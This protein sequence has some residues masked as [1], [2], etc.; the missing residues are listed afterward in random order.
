MKETNSM[1]KNRSIRINILKFICILLPLVAILTFVLWNFYFVEVKASYSKVEEEES[2]VVNDANKFFIQTFANLQSDLLFLSDIFTMNEDVFAQSSIEW[3]S[4]EFLFFSR[5][6]FV[7]DQLRFMDN[8]GIEI[9][10]INFNKG[11]PIIVEKNK[12][13]DKSEEYYFK[14]SKKINRGGVYISR[15]DL[16]LE[17]GVVERPEGVHPENFIFN[18]V[19]RLHKDVNYVKP[20][21]RL[22]TPAFDSKGEKKGVVL[23]NYFGAQLLKD[24]EEITGSSYGKSA[25]VDSEGFWLKGLEKEKEWGFV[26]DL[27]NYENTKLQDLYPRVWDL[28]SKKEAGQFYTKEGLFT[29]NTVYPLSRKYKLSL[30]SRDNAEEEKVGSNDYIWKA[31]TFVPHSKLNEMVS[32][33]KSKSLFMCAILCIFIFIGT[34]LFLQIDKRRKLFEQKEKDLFASVANEKKR[35]AQELVLLN[36]QLVKNEQQLKDANVA[37]LAREQQLKASNNELQESKL[38]LADTIEKL[39]K[40]NSSMR[41]RELRIIEIKKKIKFL[42]EKLKE[43]GR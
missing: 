17:K 42:E 3:F 33:L 14:E 7:Y 8:S 5:R 28:I 16:N 10:R 12:L 31:F 40:S 20:M 11:I 13:Q 41:G 34:Y 30:T 18:R 43:N 6:R 32:E 4:K 38:D 26:S 37:L 23:I 2:R 1:E 9:I 27:K 22:G 15:L 35:E 21:I 29:F 19:W 39:K 25:L 36:E 24:F